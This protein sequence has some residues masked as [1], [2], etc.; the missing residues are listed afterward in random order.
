MFYL[1]CRRSGSNDISAEVTAPFHGK[2][3]LPD[4]KFHVL[5]A[6]WARK[7]FNANHVSGGVAAKWIKHFGPPYS[8]SFRTISSRATRTGEF[9]GNATMGFPSQSN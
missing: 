2:H 5:S 9:S 4:K 3:S 8:P 7:F 1:L 6:F